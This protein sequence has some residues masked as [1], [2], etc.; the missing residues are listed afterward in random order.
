MALAKA[1]SAPSLEEALEMAQALVR[2]QAL[3]EA[4]AL[5]GALEQAQVLAWA[6]ELARALEL[7]Q[8]PESLQYCYQSYHRSPSLMSHRLLR[9][10]LGL[11]QTSS[12]SFS[13]FSF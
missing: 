1:S 5:E 8:E 6:R 3:E 12:S 11:D 7:V 4:S 9:R 10:L 2:A 13:S